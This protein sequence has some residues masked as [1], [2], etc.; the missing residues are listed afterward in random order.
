MSGVPRLFSLENEGSNMIEHWKIGHG[1]SIL[2]TDD[3]ALASRLRKRFPYAEY[4]RIGG[5]TFGWHFWVPSRLVRIVLRK[6][7]LKNKDLREPIGANLP[8]DERSS[9]VET[10]GDPFGNFRR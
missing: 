6:G 3:R 4:S 7:V 9:R 2:Y 1:E 5:G 8:Q 10:Q